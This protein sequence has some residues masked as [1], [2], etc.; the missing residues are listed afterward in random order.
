MRPKKFPIFA[1]LSGLLVSGAQAEWSISVSAP[2]QTQYYSTSSTTTTIYG[3]PGSQIT[4]THQVPQTVCRSVWAGSTT[5]QC[6][7]QYVT[8]EDNYV[9]PSV[10][11][12]NPQVYAPPNVV[13]VNPPVYVS[14]NPAFGYPG[15]NNG[16]PYQYPYQY[17]QP[18]YRPPGPPPTTVYNSNGATYGIG[19]DVPAYGGYVPAYGGYGSQNTGSVTIRLN[20]R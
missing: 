18:Q 7:T 17:H 15:Y 16:Y 1:L 11:Y 5:Q 6:S 2:L 9:P 8:V 13:Y 19:G 20:N 3:A 12:V 10:V 14:P 4:S